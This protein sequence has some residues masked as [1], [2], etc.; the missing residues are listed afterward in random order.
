MPDEVGSHPEDVSPEG[1]FDL[2][3]E[4]AGL[5]DSYALASSSPEGAALF[6]HLKGAADAVLSGDASERSTVD[7]SDEERAR[8][9]ALGYID[10]TAAEGTPAAPSGN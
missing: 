3:A 10:A 6:D 8:L 2:T 7:V 9:E 4:P 5:T 1:V